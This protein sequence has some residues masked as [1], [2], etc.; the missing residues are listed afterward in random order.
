MSGAK[1]P[2]TNLDPSNPDNNYVENVKVIFNGDN[3]AAT[4]DGQSIVNA[5]TAGVKNITLLPGQYTFGKPL[6]DE[7][8]QRFNTSF[9][10]DV[11]FNAEG[12]VLIGHYSPNFSGAT[13]KGLTIVN[14]QNDPRAIFGAFVGNFE[15]CSFFG[16]CYSESKDTEATLTR[17][18]FFCED[19]KNMAF[20]IGL[21]DADKTVTLNDC[22]IDGR[23]DFGA[24]GH[25][26][27]NNCTLKV[28]ATWYLYNTGTYTFN[29]CT[30]EY[31]EGAT[32]ENAGN[33]TVIGLD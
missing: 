13:V 20:H 5:L 24:S 15:D 23:C 11:T 7:G 17:C 30:I 9:G 18:K 16:A 22:E 4:T 28:R 25:I 26:I 19:T 33:A 27:F 10:P 14:G 29:N 1:V 6:Y 2:T 3:A 31:A 12:A 8:N 32:I 21:L